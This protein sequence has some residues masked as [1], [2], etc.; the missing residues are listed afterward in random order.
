MR[1]TGIDERDE[2]ET[3]AGIDARSASCD[4]RMSEDQPVS[5]VGMCP[6]APFRPAVSTNVEQ[7]SR[8]MIP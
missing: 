8:R 6:T 2:N 5:D 4:P 3:R 7:H 1:R